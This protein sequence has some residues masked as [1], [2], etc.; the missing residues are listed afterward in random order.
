[1]I[2][3]VDTNILIDVFEPDPVFGRGAMRVLK[4]A[5]SVGSIVACAV[6]WTEV[7]TAY[8]NRQEVLAEALETMGLAFS[9]ISKEASLEAAKAWFQYRK[10]GGKRDRIAADFLIGGHALIQADR[11]ITRDHKVYKRYFPD[12]DII[13]PSLI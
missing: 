7:A 2:S 10:S 8:G 6:V 4:E 3:A 9:S 1:M 11:L 5:L 13:N 12:L